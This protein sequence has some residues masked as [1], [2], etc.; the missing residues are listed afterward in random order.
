M[1]IDDLL[2]G[3]AAYFFGRRAKISK[4]SIDG[5]FT[6]LRELAA[7]PGQNHFRVNRAVVGKTNYSAISFAY[8]RVPSFVRPAADIRDIVHGFMLVVEKGDYLAV[9]KSGFEIP[10]SFKTKY[11]RPVGRARVESAVATTNAKFEQL[12]VR[13]MSGS[14]QTLRSKS[15]EAEDLE[16]AMPLGSASRYVA[17]RFRVRRDDGHFAATPSTG[18][19]AK[20]SDKAGYEILI[21]WA[22]EVI[23]KLALE[24]GE[25]AP[26][27]RNFARAVELESVAADLK[28][29]VVAI[30]VPS[31]TEQLFGDTPTISFVTIADEQEVPFDKAATDAV[32]QALDESFP[33]LT[34]K[35][36]VH[37]RDVDNARN[38]GTL[39]LGKGRI[40]LSKLDIEPIQG[41]LVKSIGADAGGDG[42]LKPLRRHIDNENLFLILFADPALAYVN[43][44]LFRDEVMLSGGAEFMRHII[45]NAA[46]TNANSEKG[47]FTNTAT[48]FSA[49]SVFRILI[50]ELSGDDDVLICDDLGDEW[51]DF[52]GLDTDEHRPSITF[53]HAKHG[54][55]SLGASPFHVSISQAEKNLGRMSLA[56]STMAQKYQAWDATY[57]GPKVA[58]AI[59]RIARGGDIAAIQSQVEAIRT[60]P[61]A[62]KR[63][64]IV[65]SSL[66]RAAVGETFAQIAAGARPS[67][68]FVQLYWLLTSYFSACAELG[69]VGYVMCQP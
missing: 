14:K 37:V 7:E 18:R 12:A 28:P 47:K 23:D 43:G 4:A 8:K 3:S 33:I 42:E 65:T 19:I 36:G 45:G 53:Y 66:S 22:E 24:P 52:I 48:Q 57:N 50:D 31:L 61:A 38:I 11:L 54:P 30:D 40:A 39:K 69:T 5:L 41:V 55:L 20:R 1:T 34:N 2:V 10:S 16:N 32:L 26:F 63:A 6:K 35:Q 67:A 68:H 17:N 58:S 62:T 21:E 51:A 44:E 25:V 60:A 13:S 9:V 29:I 49:Q 46:L 64:I 15:V 59:P 27:I 56:P